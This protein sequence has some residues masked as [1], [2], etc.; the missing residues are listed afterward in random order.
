MVKGVLGGLI[1]NKIQPYNVLFIVSNKFFP[2]FALKHQC[3]TFD[4]FVDGATLRR[5]A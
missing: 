4:A 2:E 5:T 1:I 3:N